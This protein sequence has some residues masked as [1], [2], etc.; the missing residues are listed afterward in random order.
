MAF[1]N[2]LLGCLLCLIVTGCGDTSAPNSSDSTGAAAAPTNESIDLGAPVTP[3]AASPSTDAVPPPPAPP[4]G[5]TAPPNGAAAAPDRATVV[6]DEGVDLRPIADDAAL[7]VLLRPARALGNPVVQ[8]VIQA[9]EEVQP[10]FKLSDRLAEMREEVGI[11]ANDIDH[12]L[13]VVDKQQLA[14]AASLGGL[15]MGPSPGDFQLE[16]APESAIPPPDANC[17]DQAATTEA[18][19]EFA[20]PGPGGE[21]PAESQP[22]VVIRF[23]RAVDQQKLASAGGN[24]AEP[25][26]HAGQT[27]YTKAD[28]SA[29]WFEDPQTVMIASEPKVLAAIDGKV[30]A[31]GALA[32]VLGPLTSRELAVVLDVRELH[33]LVG[34][35]AQQNPMAA[36]AGGLV[37]QVNTLTLAVDLEGEHLLRLQMHTL[38]ES[39][40]GGLQGMLGGFLQQG[41]QAFKQQMQANAESLGEEEKALVPLVDSLVSG[42]TVTAD[43]AVCSITVPRP[44]G[45]E[46]LPQLIRPALAK[47]AAQTA[48]SN[49]MNS[50][51]QIA[52]GFHNY[53]DVYG[54]LPAHGGPGV[55]G[56]KGVG[57]SWRVHLLPFLDEIALYEEFHL[58]EPWDSEHNKSLVSRMPK[59]FGANPEGK[60]AIHVFTGEGAPFE[61]G[62]GLKFSQVTDGTSNTILIVQAGEDT[63]DFWTKPGGLTFNPAEPLAALGNVGD[64]I[65]VVRMDGS[66]TVLPREIDPQ[67]FKLLVQHADGNPVPGF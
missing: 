18:Q 67:I 52:L 10:N 1:R 62:Q 6:G 59:V 47:M 14:M 2:W 12:V 38:N 33:E 27:Y 24:P 21:Q 37:K 11:D 49:E 58:D 66:A 65:R 23:N 8:G 17:D 45:L 57:L 26:T 50:L 20:P 39:S 7:V 40:A 34:M 13:V 56:A 15:L 5:A 64:Q 30:G 25:K 29:A 35:M 53:H 61:G 51:R 43:G 42:T 22:T 19:P 28:K 54:T 41:Q 46:Q 36:M 16:S 44:A 31:P 55:E 3:D 9:V 32:A 4:S 48:A 63:A 60:T